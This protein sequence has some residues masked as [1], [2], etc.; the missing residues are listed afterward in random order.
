[1]I[2]TVFDL[3]YQE[4]VGLFQVLSNILENFSQF[5]LCHPRM[6]VPRRPEHQAARNDS[7]WWSR[8]PT[9]DYQIQRL[10]IHS[11]VAGPAQPR[12]WLLLY[13]LARTI[14]FQKAQTR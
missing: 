9:G 8:W 5:L 6:L 2:V 4:L 13:C 1:M 3:C 7:T 11:R 14:F 12:L 10:A